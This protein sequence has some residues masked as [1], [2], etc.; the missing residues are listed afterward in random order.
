M[1]RSMDIENTQRLR[2]T[3]KKLEEAFRRYNVPGKDQ[4]A[5]RAIQQ[6]CVGLK[7]ENDY[8]TEKASRIATLAG[9]YY[10]ARYERHPGGE[11]DLMSEMSFQLPNV[12]RSQISYLE[13]LQGDAEV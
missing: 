12:I 2:E 10:S 13:R 5:L 9:I 11:T 3:L 8:I 1:W 6:L 7:G 4:S